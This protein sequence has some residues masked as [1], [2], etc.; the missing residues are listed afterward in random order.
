[1]R[2]EREETQRVLKARIALRRCDARGSRVRDECQAT[3]P[4]RLQQGLLQRGQLH[5]NPPERVE[6]DAIQSQDIG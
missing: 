5:F 6:V 4:P 3:H 1:M 2:D